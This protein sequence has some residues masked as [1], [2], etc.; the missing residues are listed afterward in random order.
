ME[1][2]TLELDNLNKTSVQK[3][4]NK[5]QIINDLLLIIEENKYF[6]NPECSIDSL[7]KKIETNRQY[8]SVIINDK[9]DSNFN[10]FINTYRI[11]EARKL[12]LD[13]EYD[14]Y[15]IDAIAKLSGFKT[16]A[17]F[18]AAFKKITGVTPSFFKKEH[19]QFTA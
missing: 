3:I 18:N 16:K 2:D 7:A 19:L 5:Q 10:Q 12:L 1:I 17:T 6:L 15:T 4:S 11:K 8:L 14:K 13:K 9:F